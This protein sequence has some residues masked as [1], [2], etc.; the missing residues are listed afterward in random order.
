M[1]ATGGYGFK[2]LDPT[3]ATYH[4]RRDGSQEIIYALPRPGK[5]WGPW[6]VH[7][8]PAE[9]D[10]EACGHGRFHLHKRLSFAH[11]P[12]RGW[13]WF[14]Q[15]E[16]LVGED[17][18][19]IAVRRL[20]LRRIAPRVLWR[21]LHSP[22]NWGCEAD[23]SWAN[24]SWANLHGANL[25]GADLHGADLRW[26]NLGEADLTGAN[27]SWADLHGADLRWADLTGAN[28]SWADLRWA[29]LHEAIGLSG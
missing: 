14:A 8:C 5:K 11:A 29:N 19:K 12:T 25:H 20:R 18:E 24:L 17:D 28:L 22:F 26:A 4:E 10:G 15:W 23:L 13:P 16:G 21:A 1:A 6:N 7:P 9:P 2:I 27:L 3:G